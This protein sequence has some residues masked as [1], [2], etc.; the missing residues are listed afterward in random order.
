MHAIFVIRLKGPRHSSHNPLD[1]LRVQP[2]N[3]VHNFNLTEK[4]KKNV[5]TPAKHVLSLSSQM[6][7]HE[8]GSGQSLERKRNC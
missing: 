2:L 8:N 1:G 5:T 4:Q 7:W 6:S 3:Y